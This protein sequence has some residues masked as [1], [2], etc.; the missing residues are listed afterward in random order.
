MTEN[1]S[2]SLS[3]QGGCDPLLWRLIERAQKGDKAA[4]E[5]L[6]VRSE[7]RVVSI[8]WKMLGNED[9]ARDAAQDAFFRL[10]KYLK[11]YRASEDFDGWLY[12]IVINVCRDIRRKRKASTVSYESERDAGA[13]ESLVSEDDIEA[14]AIESQ[15]RQIVAQALD[16]LSKK[17]REALVLR[18]L[19]GLSTSEVAR[20]LGSSETTVRSQISTA[21]SKIKAFKDRLLKQYRR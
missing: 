16:S 3:Y 7:R 14:K 9:D 17:E 11:S 21:R 6:M 13:L 2:L 12:R 20:I 8:A 5:D 18:D 10:Y 1:R 15:Q 4:F 19:E